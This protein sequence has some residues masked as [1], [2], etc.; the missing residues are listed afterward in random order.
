MAKNLSR[1]MA[2]LAYTFFWF[3]GMLVYLFSRGD[4]YA[5]FHALQSIMMFGLLTLAQII[6]IATVLG[7]LL[8]P[9]V[10]LLCIITWTVLIIKAWQGE[11]FK[12]PVIGAIAEA[13]VL[14]KE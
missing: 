14:H 10:W 12:L 5:R 9:V 1:A 8:L 13:H 6:L 4:D 11:W 2:M 3:S 7:I